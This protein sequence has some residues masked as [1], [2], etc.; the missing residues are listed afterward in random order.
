MKVDPGRGNSIHDGSEQGNGKEVSKGE[1]L[2]GK[3]V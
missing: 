3:S 1:T 2:T